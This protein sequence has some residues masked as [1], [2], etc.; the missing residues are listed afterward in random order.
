MVTNSLDFLFPYFAE[1]ITKLN[2]DVNPNRFFVFE[3]YR[4]FDTQFEYYKKGRELVKD[5]WQVVDKTQVVTN[6]KPGDSWHAYGLA[7]D[8]AVD[9]NPQKSGLQWTWE[10]YDLTLPGKQT[11]P[12]NKLG[13]P[14]IGLGLEWAGNWVTFKEFP[15]I[16]NRLGFNIMDLKKSLINDGIQTV[17]TKLETKIPP[18]KDCIVVPTELVTS[19]EKHN[20]VENTIPTKTGIINRLLNLFT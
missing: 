19:D 17:W 9:G 14:C 18:R 3:T 13:G 10:D 8:Y 15:H 1:Q 16:Q 11:I 2:R 5:V 20:I 6:A 4:S 7:V 12:W